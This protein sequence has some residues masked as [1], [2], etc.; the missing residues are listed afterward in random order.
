VD[1]FKYRQG[2][3]SNVILLPTLSGNT[4]TGGSGYC[5]YTSVGKTIT[6]TVDCQLNYTAGGLSPELIVLQNMPSISTGSTSAAIG[7]FGTSTSVPGQSGPY[8]LAY[9]SGSNTKWGIYKGDGTAASY[10]GS[11]S[12]TNTVS[13]Q[14]SFSF[15]GTLN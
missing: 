10:T 14:A 11:G 7:S 9:V 8:T 6:F 2:S 12:G 13:I 5:Y 15:Y 4:F 1:Y 3:V